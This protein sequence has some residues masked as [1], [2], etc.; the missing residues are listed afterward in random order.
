M[1]D[2]L[3]LGVMV[4]G[5]GTNLQSLIDTC[6]AGLVDAEV[7]LVISNKADAYALERARKH[8]IPAVHVPVGRNETPEYF[9]AD[10]EQVRLFREHGV[11]LV[12]MAGY[13]R[14]AGPALLG[15]YSQAVLNIHPALLPAFPGVH[16][17]WHAVD[18]GVR[19]SG[20][21][22][23]FADEEFDRGP[24]IIQAAVPVLQDDDG[25]ALAGRILRQ[26][27]KIYPQAVQWFAQGRLQIEGRRVIVRDA[28]PGDWHD[29][30][31]ISPA[32]ELPL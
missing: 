15:A 26:E 10:E 28:R 19:I 23:H 30:A 2:K 21:T 22:V 12:C 25:D 4:S 16:V 17:Q 29:G 24:I 11:E 27:H 7:V 6:E 31:I 32:L 9:R 3:R 1:A 20:C 14:K 5:G 8:S 13:L 18:Y